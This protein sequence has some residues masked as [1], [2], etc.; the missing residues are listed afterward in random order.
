[1]NTIKPI[2]NAGANGQPHTGKS[3]ALI[4]AVDNLRRIATC[5]SK[6]MSQTQTVAKVAI[7]AMIMNTFSGIR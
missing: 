6:I 3:S 5:E 2:A 1:M 7:D 4:S